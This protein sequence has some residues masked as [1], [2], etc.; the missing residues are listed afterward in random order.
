MT[1]SEM[2]TAIRVQLDKT[3]SFTYGAFESEELDYWLN[4]AQERFIKQRLYGN[5]YK[6]EKYDDTQKRID[7]IKSLVKIKSALSLTNSLLGGNVVDV[8]LPTTDATAPY[9]FYLNSTVYNSVGDALQTGDI[10]PI[11]LLNLYVKDSINEP[12]ILRPLVV[13][14]N[15]TVDKIAFVYG[16][17][18]T[19]N[20]C[21]I[22]YVK[23]PKK[24]VSG[25][26]GTYETNTSELP[27]HTH[28]EIVTICVDM[29]IE[30][31]ESP[32]VQTFTQLNASKIE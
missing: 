22:L 20:T 9:M 16:D 21:D 25:T 13:F 26:P 23:K 27:E 4:E 3:S 11:E 28:K 31:I 6:Q 17:E 1:V 10:L 5:N 19:P 14:F 24:L 15:D 2:H 8:A 12:Y 30:N 29:L 7:D 32:R 18:F